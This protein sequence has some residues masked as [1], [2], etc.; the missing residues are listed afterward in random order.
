MHTSQEQTPPTLVVAIAP[1]LRQR[2]DDV[3]LARQV[4]V[5][6]PAGVGAMQTKGA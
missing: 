2:V 3:D 5:V 6:V 1:G 4:G